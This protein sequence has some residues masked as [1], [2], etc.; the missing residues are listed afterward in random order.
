MAHL[1]LIIFYQYHYNDDLANNI[2][3]FVN[4]QNNDFLHRH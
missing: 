3:Y 1:F 2:E 4:D